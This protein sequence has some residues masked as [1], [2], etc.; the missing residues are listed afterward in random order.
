MRYLQKHAN[1]LFPA[2]L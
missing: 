2:I 1:E